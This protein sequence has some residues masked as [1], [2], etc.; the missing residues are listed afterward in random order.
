MDGDGV[1]RISFHRG[2]ET[3]KVLRRNGDGEEDEEEEEEEAEP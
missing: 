3:L 2:A 1:E